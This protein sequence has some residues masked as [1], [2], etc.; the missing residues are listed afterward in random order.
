MK[1][2]DDGRTIWTAVV[3]WKD[4]DPLYSVLGYDKQRVEQ[5]AQRIMKEEAPRKDSAPSWT[6]VFNT[7]DAAGVVLLDDMQ[8]RELEEE[9]LVVTTA[10]P[11]H[12]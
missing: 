12:L 9:E 5:E 6:G 4:C 3:W 10:S 8:M 2:Y 11:E 1:R 7:A